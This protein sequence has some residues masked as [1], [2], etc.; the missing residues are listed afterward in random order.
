M[1]TYGNHHD[2]HAGAAAQAEWMRGDN[3]TP[4]RRVYHNPPVQEVVLSLAFQQPADVEALEALPA[5]LEGLFSK[6]DRRERSDF[7]IEVGPAGQ[8]AMRAN[9]QFD[10]WALMNDGPT[11]VVHAGHKH[12]SLHAVRP[13]LWPTGPYAGWQT[14]HGEMLDVLTRL[15]P[16]YAA[17]PMFRVGVRYL[18]RLAAPLGTDLSEWLTVTLQGPSVLRDPHTFNLR[19]TWARV[20][21]H[22]DVSATIGVARIEIP[23]TEPT[24][25]ESCVGIL[26]DIEVFNLWVHH[27]PVFEDVPEWTARAHEV[28]NAIFEGCITDALRRRLGTA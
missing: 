15:A 6:R 24:L 2:E 10:G 25:R 4:A 16:V 21:G 28:E 20:A 18:N 17:L 7:E 9:K 23:E 8:S 5:C 11:R 14:I 1:E 22:A 12:V 3:R 27:A 13:G 19:Q 26:L